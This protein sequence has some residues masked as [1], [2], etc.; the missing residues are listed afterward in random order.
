MLDCFSTHYLPTTVKKAST[1]Y[2]RGRFSIYGC[3]SVAGNTASYSGAY[4]RFHE[5]RCQRPDR[6]WSLPSCL[7]NGY[8]GFFIRGRATRVCSW[9]L[10]S[11][12]HRG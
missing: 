11:I 8:R 7:F 5:G 1:P 12:W 2:V 9:P 6:L 10:T 4:W 3:C